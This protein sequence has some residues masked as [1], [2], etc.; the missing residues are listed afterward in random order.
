MTRLLAL[1][2]LSLTLACAACQS[3]GVASSD[4]N[5]QDQNSI[6]D[7]SR[8]G[9]SGTINPRDNANTPT[10]GND[11]GVGQSGSSSANENH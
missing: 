6:Q 4:Q 3:S 9:N 8:V 2:S 5:M 10:S 11:Q 7:Q 1:A